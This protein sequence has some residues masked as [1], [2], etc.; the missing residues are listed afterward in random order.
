MSYAK[1]MKHTRNVR[2]C[3]KQANN[4]MGF[5]A[6]TGNWPNPR[7][8]PEVAAMIQVKDWYRYRHH[9][10]KQYNRECIREAIADLRKIRAA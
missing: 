5:D 9:G 4:Y 10:D 2:K 7:R 3:R 8:N 6:G 1:A